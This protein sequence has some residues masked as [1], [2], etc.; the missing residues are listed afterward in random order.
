MTALKKQHEDTNVELELGI[1]TV[2]AKSRAVS[3]RRSRRG[4]SSEHTPEIEKYSEGSRRGSNKKEIDWNQVQPS[5]N[6]H[7]VHGRRATSQMNIGPST[8]TAG[9]G[10]EATWA[11]G[12][13]EGEVAGRGRKHGWRTATE[14]TNKGED[15]VLDSILDEIELLKRQG[16]GGGEY[17][18]QVRILEQEAEMLRHQRHHSG[19]SHS[20]TREGVFDSNRPPQGFRDTRSKQFETAGYFGDVEMGSGSMGRGYTGNNNPS[21]AGMYYAPGNKPMVGGNAMA[22]PGMMGAAPFGPAQGMMAGMDPMMY[23]MQ[24][25]QMQLWQS[26]QLMQQNK[27]ENERLQKEMEKEQQTTYT[28]VLGLLASRFM[29]PGVGNPP[30]IGVGSESQ[31]G[32]S[33]GQTELERGWADLEKLN[34]ESDIYKMRQ[35]HLL[36]LT[37]LQMEK[38]LHEKEKELEVAKKADTDGFEAT[39]GQK[40]PRPASAAQYPYVPGD[41]LVLFWDYVVGLPQC[42][43]CEVTYIFCQGEKTIGKGPPKT[44]GFHP[45]KPQTSGLRSLCIIGAKKQF[46]QIP[47][48]KNMKIIVEVKVQRSGSSKVETIG[49]A[50]LDMFLTSPSGSEKINSGWFRVPC[51][52]PPVDRSALSYNLASNYHLIEGMFIF[53]RLV[54]AA[55]AAKL[56]AGADPSHT[57]HMFSFAPIQPPQI[58]FSSILRPEPTISSQSKAQLAVPAQKTP[59]AGPATKSQP[60][61][62]HDISSVPS[63]AASHR[64]ADTVSE[65]Q[66]VADMRKGGDG[67]GVAEWKFDDIEEDSEGEDQLYKSDEGFGLVLEKF[68]QDTVGS[69]ALYTRYLLFHL[70]HLSHQSDT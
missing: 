2:A 43:E 36:K 56:T 69:E 64:S 8:G 1:P 6:K 19:N 24:Q 23:Q 46:S 17:A 31:P 60:V 33:G 21:H 70:F 41:G 44:I 22:F 10:E 25:I 14:R 57:Q 39:F 40:R 59:S 63:T 12:A 58:D 16:G 13:E 20:R 50:L 66:H 32:A 54:T 42:A 45:V 65:G 4:S 27:E 38:E 9:A 62:E 3:G 51:Y 67:D 68:Y 48:M 28:N 55:E 7:P 18:E 52:R 5:R 53:M 11:T 37:K 61:V 15:P 29:A 47:A 26:Q 30:S 49:W 34:P 35:A